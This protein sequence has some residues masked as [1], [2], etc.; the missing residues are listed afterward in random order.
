M[1]N[2]QENTN[3][4]RKGFSRIRENIDFSRQFPNNQLPHEVNSTTAST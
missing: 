1:N 4:C 2:C 3:L